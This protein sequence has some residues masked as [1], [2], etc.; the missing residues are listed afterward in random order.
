[1]KG[2]IH[3][4]AFTQWHFGT[5]RAGDIVH[6]VSVHGSC[7]KSYNTLEACICQAFAASFSSPVQ[8]TLLQRSFLSANH[9][10][11]NRFCTF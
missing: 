5:T 4:M 6:Y 3:L 11:E 7:H 10:L 8:S 1:M 2:I 9:Q